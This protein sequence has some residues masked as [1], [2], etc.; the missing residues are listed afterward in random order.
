MVSVCVCLGRRGLPIAFS[1]FLPGSLFIVILRRG[2]LSSAASRET[3]ERAKAWGAFIHGG[4]AGDPALGLPYKRWS[5]YDWLPP[6]TVI[7]TDIADTGH[8]L[9][10]T[11]RCRPSR[12]ANE[13]LEM[14]APALHRFRISAGPRLSLLYNVYAMLAATGVP[15]IVGAL[16]P[17][18]QLSRGRTR[19][20]VPV[21]EQPT[22]QSCD[23]RARRIMNGTALFPSSDDERASFRLI[24]LCWDGGRT[25]GI[26]KALVGDLIC[27]MAAGWSSFSGHGFEARSGR[28][29]ERPQLNGDRFDGA[30]SVAWAPGG[31]WL[32]RTR[33]PTSNDSAHGSVPA[34]PPCTPCTTLP[35]AR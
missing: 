3:R 18:S 24:V 31:E 11:A 10:A 14:P 23:T 5:G 21:S 25:S 2:G 33:A 6:N 35:C 32:P 7:H 13:H 4:Q 9:L 20:R 8:T 17:S 16:L 30:Q 12:P 29:V 22:S 19:H 34:S 27:T 15:L 26:A 28:I 1:S